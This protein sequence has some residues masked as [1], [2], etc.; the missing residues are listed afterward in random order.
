MDGISIQI[1]IIP[2]RILTTIRPEPRTAEHRRAQLARLCIRRPPKYPA[3]LHEM[4]N[5]IIS[6]ARK[7]EK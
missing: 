5:K 1:S 7:F 2:T 4:L 3:G 6:V